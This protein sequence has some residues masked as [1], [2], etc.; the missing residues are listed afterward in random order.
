MKKTHK[1]KKALKNLKYDSQ[2]EKTLTNQMIKLNI[3]SVTNGEDEKKIREAEAES[4]RSTIQLREV[5]E[6]RRDGTKEKNLL[7]E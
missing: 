6:N 1:T 3:F 4:K 5:P 2:S 7:K